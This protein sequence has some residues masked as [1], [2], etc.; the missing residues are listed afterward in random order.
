M[1]GRRHQSKI[2]NITNQHPALYRLDA[3]LSPTNSVETLKDVINI[4]IT[5]KKFI[6]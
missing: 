2:V 4:T 6:H 3:F 5:I 1:V